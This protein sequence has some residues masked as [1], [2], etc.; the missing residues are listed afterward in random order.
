MRPKL[1]P[2]L[3]LLRTLRGLDDEICPVTPYR[4]VVNFDIHGLNNF[5]SLKVDSSPRAGRVSRAPGAPTWD[6]QPDPHGALTR[7]G[8]RTGGAHLTAPGA[9]ARPPSEILPADARAAATSFVAV[10]RPTR[11]ARPPERQPTHGR[12]RTVEDAAAR[13]RRRGGPA[14]QSYLETPY[15]NGFCPVPLSGGRCQPVCKPN[16]LP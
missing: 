11:A 7:S 13:T 3:S 6:R 2:A 15:K 4:V 9:V 16:P 14:G 12:R 8:M 5:Y 10:A 1:L